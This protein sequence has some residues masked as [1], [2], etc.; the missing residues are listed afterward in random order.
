MR[1]AGTHNHKADR[2]CRLA[3]ADLASP[4][5]A[6]DRLVAGL[7]DPDPPPP[8]PSPAQRARQDA[9]LRS[10]D[11]TRLDPPVYFA[12]LAAREVGDR[13]GFVPCPLPDHTEQMSSCMV[14][15]N[16][17]RGWWCYGCQRGGAIY[18]LASL[19]EG[20]PWG[21]DLRGDHFTEV[22]RRVHDQLGLGPPPQRRHRAAGVESDRAAAGHPS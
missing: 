5:I 15:P 11:A 9:W 7:T 8:P 21:H 13:G 2:S 16:S 12:A 17:Q 14:Y 20:G 22:K 18:D 1:V 3:Y 19:L 6:P 10:D 4:P